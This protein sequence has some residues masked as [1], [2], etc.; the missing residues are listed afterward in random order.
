RVR[1]EPAPRDE[2]GQD[3]QH[4]VDRD[5]GELL[6]AGV[7]ERGADHE[8]DEAGGRQR[9]E[10]GRDAER[11]RQD[12]PERAQ[13]LH[14]ADALDRTGREVLGPGQAK[15]REL[16]LG[17]GQLHQ[18]GDDERGGQQPRDDPQRE[19]HARTV[20]PAYLTRQLNSVDASSYSE[21]MDA[22][23]EPRWLTEVEMRAWLELISVLIRLPAALD[24]QL[25]RDAGLSHF[26]YQV[27][28]GLSMSPER[29]MR[30]RDLAAF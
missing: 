26:E 20:A 5:G 22:T 27:L 1:A 9:G 19:V 6:A 12:E 15:G 2:R 7:R 16:L 4:G 13:H 21:G 23:D 29:T 14:D 8:Q 30:M 25:Q 18:A 11:R 10:H 3:Q 24:R 17:L 28:A